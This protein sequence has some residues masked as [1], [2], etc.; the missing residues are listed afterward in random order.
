MAD[1]SMCLD[2]ECPSRVHCYRFRAIPN[3]Y[4]QS[5]FVDT[6]R[7]GKPKCDHYWSASGWDDRSLRKM[8]EIEIKPETEKAEV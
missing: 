5:Y 1:I 8:S 4:R 3:Q 6:Q 7:E 2:T